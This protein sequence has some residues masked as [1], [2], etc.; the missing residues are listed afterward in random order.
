[1]RRHSAVTDAVAA[2]SAA[3]PPGP[4]AAAR[5]RSEVLAPMQDLLTAVD[6]FVVTDPALIAVHD[7]IRESVRLDIE[8][9]RLLADALD[10]DD[11]AKTYEAADLLDRG[12]SQLGAWVRG[13]DGL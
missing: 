11:V 10:T 2:I 3:D 9:Y 7:H 13:V 8:G 4:A 12:T 6:S 5:I 1:V